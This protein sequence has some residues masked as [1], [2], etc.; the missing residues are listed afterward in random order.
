MIRS[1]L[2]SLTLGA[3]ASSSSVTGASSSRLPAQQFSTSI[4]SS[5]AKAVSAYSLPFQLTPSSSQ[6][7]SSNTRP[8]HVIPYAQI[9]FPR[10][11][12]QTPKDFIDSISTPPRRI[13]SEDS[14]LMTAVGETWESLWKNDRHSL[15]TAGVAVKERRYV[16]WAMEKFRQGYNPEQFRIKPKKKKIVRGWGP[17]VQ[18][19]FRVSGRRRPGEKSL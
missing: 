9:P 7:S 6:P 16:L 2:R 18:H 10:G 19:G 13:L 3:S 1:A 14:S 4:A 5:K 15:K 17:R 11:S 12:I 8:Q